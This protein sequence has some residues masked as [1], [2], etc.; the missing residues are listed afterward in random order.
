[1]PFQNGKLLAAALPNARLE[2]VEGGGHLPFLEN[3]EGFAESVTAFLST[4]K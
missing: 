2:T 3:P 1:V 4:L